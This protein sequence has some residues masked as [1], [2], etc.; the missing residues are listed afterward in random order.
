MDKICLCSGLTRHAVMQGAGHGE[1]AGDQ[2]SDVW[3]MDVSFRLSFKIEKEADFCTK[4]Q[5]KSHVKA[6]SEQ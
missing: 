3:R 2:T 1:S 6:V 5:R 4:E